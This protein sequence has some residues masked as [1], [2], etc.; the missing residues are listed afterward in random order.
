MLSIVVLGAITYRHPQLII[1]QCNDCPAQTHPT[2]QS[3][4]AAAAGERDAPRPRGARARVCR[5]GG[6]AAQLSAHGMPLMEPEMWSDEQ[7]HTGAPT[8]TSMTADPERFVPP[9][10]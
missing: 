9:W 7:M 2:A 10:Y 1:R 6:Y 8:S 3:P 4:A 5:P